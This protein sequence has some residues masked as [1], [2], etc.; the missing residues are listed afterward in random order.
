MSNAGTTAMA[1][2]TDTEFYDLINGITEPEPDTPMGNELT[3]LRAI[4]RQ[5]NKYADAIEAAAKKGTMKD[6]F[7]AVSQ[8]CAGNPLNDDCTVV[9]LHYSGE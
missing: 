1:V 6:I 4:A 5:T 8:F 3:Y 7:D 2:P 9:E